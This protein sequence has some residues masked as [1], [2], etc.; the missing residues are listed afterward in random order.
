L[1]ETFT[2]AQ[3][4]LLSPEEAADLQA[5]LGEETIGRLACA[6]QCGGSLG[7]DAF[8]GSYAIYGRANN[9]F[10]PRLNTMEFLRPVERL[11]YTIN[12]YHC[13]DMKALK[14]KILQFPKGSMFGFAYDFSAAD[15]DEILEIVAFLRTQGYRVGGTHTWSF[16]D[17]NPPQ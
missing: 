4:W 6:F 14:E 3:G 17:P 8:A 1:V 10:D 16:W 5:L 13:D 15:K 7:T 11:Y 9:N 2:R 12:Q